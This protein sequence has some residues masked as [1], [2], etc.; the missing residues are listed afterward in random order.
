MYALCVSA[1]QWAQRAGLALLWGHT[2]LTEDLL[3]TTCGVWM[4][5]VLAGIL[6]W[7]SG[8]VNVHHGLR[9]DPS[10]PSLHIFFCLR[11]LTAICPG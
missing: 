10:K 3:E 4:N 2:L 8:F 5:P 11:W 9:F 7:I 6:W 1:R